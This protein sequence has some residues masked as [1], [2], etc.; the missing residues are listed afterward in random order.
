MLLLFMCI[1]SFLNM[2]NVEIMSLLAIPNT[3][4]FMIIQWVSQQPLQCPSYNA[5]RILSSVLQLS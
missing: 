5:Q 4:H 2:F 1:L 3:V